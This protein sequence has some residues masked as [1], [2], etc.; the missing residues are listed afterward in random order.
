M[1]KENIFVTRDRIEMP[2]FVAGSDNLPDFAKNCVRDFGDGFYEFKYH[3]REFLKCKAGDIIYYGGSHG[4]DT[5]LSVLDPKRYIVKNGVVY[6][7]GAIYQA[8]IVDDNYPDFLSDID[9]SFDGVSWHL[10]TPR[11]NIKVHIG[12]YWI[13][14]LDPEH[15]FGSP[16]VSTI[17]RDGGSFERFWRCDI[18]GTFIEKLSA[19]DRRT[20]TPSD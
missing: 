11:L 20:Y 8:R 16:I 4:R 10:K 1:L 9:I 6:D 13:R 15:K 2:A 19:Y 3:E 7:K 14:D 12:D 17:E 18:D 5:Y